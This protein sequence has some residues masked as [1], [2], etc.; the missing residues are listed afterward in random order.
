MGIP[1]ETHK[2]IVIDKEFK[3]LIPP[4]TVEEYAQLEE[5]ILKE[6]CRD[7][8]V[9]WNGILIDGHS[10]YEI[11]RK[12]GIDFQLVRKEFVNREAV[13]D[14]IINNQ[15]GRRNLTPAN[16][17][18]LRGMQYEREKKKVP[19]EQGLNQFSKVGGKSCTQPKTDERLAERYNVSP[20]TIKNDAK[21][22][23]AVDTIVQNTAPEVKQQILN[24]EIPVTK[25]DTLELAKI[26]PEIQKQVIQEVITGESKSVKE[27][28]KK[29]TPHVAYN[30]GNNQWYTPKEYIEAA[31]AVMGDIDLDPASSEI[32]NKVVNAKQIYTVEDDGLTKDWHGK[33]WLNPPY[34]GELISLFCNKIANHYKDG[35]V[36]EAIILVNNATETGWFN[37]LII[38]ASAVVFPKGRVKF[39]APDGTLA[40]PL[41]GQ[42]VIYLG[43]NPDLFLQCFR[44]FG[45]GARVT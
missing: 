35:E 33:V 37:T 27:A 25:K 7:A 39:Y 42:A 36:T 14:W 4:L 43:Q 29:K 18:Y 41:Q 15:L 13:I 26:E 40:A 2:S 22:T 17:S 11:C 12:Y 31:R 10:R 9:L 23:R 32:A 30:N 44:S 3:N 38:Q 1:A 24:R 21:F 16:Q 28:I 19:N 6:G 20:R 34:A 8:L 45:W 5:S